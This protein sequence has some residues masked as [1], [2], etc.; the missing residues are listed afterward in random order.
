[1]REHDF[2]DTN[3]FLRFFTA[4]VPGQSENT[5]RLIDEIAR[6]SAEVITSDLVIAELVW[7]ME[8]FYKLPVHEIVTKLSFILNLRGLKLVNKSLILEALEDYE[9]HH[10]DYIDAYNAAFMK[11]HGIKALYS[12]DKDY[13]RM[14]ITRL[15]P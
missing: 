15:E 5:K 1:M 12:Y 8:S 13:D 4:D 14:G 2:I 9:Q 6:G 10:V 3:I 11:S 7:V